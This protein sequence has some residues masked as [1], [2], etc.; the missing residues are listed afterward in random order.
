MDKNITTL[1][2]ENVLVK[3]ELADLK[4]SVQFHS[5]MVEEQTKEVKRKIEKSNNVR[6][7]SRESDKIVMDK[8]AELEDRSRRNN[9]RFDGIREDDK[10]TW[11]ISENKIRN[12]IQ[13]ELDLNAEE[14]TIERAHRSGKT[15]INGERNYKRTIVARFLNY[16]DKNKVLNQFRAKKLWNKNI[17][18]NEDFSGTTMELRKGLFRQAKDLKEKGM[19]AKVVYNKIITHEWRETRQGVKSTQS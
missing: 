4:L 16:K 19:F 15:S 8:V 10:E 5:D 3:K 11:E 17:Y 2:G 13:N 1:I 7:S 6:E 18:I 12:I 9:L 14:I